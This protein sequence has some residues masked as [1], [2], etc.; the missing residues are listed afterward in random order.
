MK[1]FTASAKGFPR[2]T[3]TLHVVYRG[4]R[5]RKT[6]HYGSGQFSK[7][8]KIHKTKASADKVAKSCKISGIAYRIVKLKNGYRVDKKF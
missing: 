3:Q 6:V 1:S 7:T 8:G 5:G 4:G 2:Y